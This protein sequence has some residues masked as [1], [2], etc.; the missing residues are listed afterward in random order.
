VILWLGAI[1]DLAFNAVM[2]LVAAPR[3][4]QLA[5]VV[6]SALEISAVAHATDV[7][8]DRMCDSRSRAGPTK[9]VGVMTKDTE[10]SRWVG[11][12]IGIGAGVGVAF[13][14][15]LGGGPGIAIGAGIGAGIGVA[16][17]AATAPSRSDGGS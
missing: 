6:Q 7:L 1:A 8:L 15:V 11:I 13:G 17:G 5:V 14:V 16:L 9:D 3:V 2:F 4:G 10:R 12:A